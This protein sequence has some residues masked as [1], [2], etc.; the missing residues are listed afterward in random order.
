MKYKSF[1]TDRLYLR[2]TSESDSEFIFKLLNTPKWL[3][4]IDDRKIKSV[5][6]TRKYIKDIM[7][8]QLESHG[9]STYTLITK[10]NNQKVG[11]C[12]LFNKNNIKRVEIGFALLPEYEKNGFAFE[13]S[14]KLI[15][16]ASNEFGINTVWA[17]TKKDNIP[18]QRL[19]EKL[20][21]ELIGTTKIP[22][23]NEE[24]LLYKIEM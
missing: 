20:G 6:N 16:V 3:K 21:L 22:K 4:Y 13:S 5:L 10:C 18:S 14:N 1:E 11:I 17:V 19:I 24:L 23:Q 7:I 2:P 8:S 15:E 9:Y 12:G